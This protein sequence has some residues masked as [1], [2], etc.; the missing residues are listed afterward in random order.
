MRP[1]GGHHQTVAQPETP[2]REHGMSP[3]RPAFHQ[4]GVPGP[5][6]DDFNLIPGDSHDAAG[7]SRD[8]PSL[9]LVSR[10]LQIHGVFV[11][12]RRPEQ[13]VDVAEVC[14]RTIQHRP[15][16]RDLLEDLELRLKPFDLVMQ[17]SSL[18]KPL[19]AAGM[20]RPSS[21]R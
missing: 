15:C 18:L 12:D 16:T 2:N 10:Q 3:F 4:T 1:G 11:P 7:L 19:Y 21:T 8:L 20:P 14:L 13:P 5:E 6:R 9:H 17:L